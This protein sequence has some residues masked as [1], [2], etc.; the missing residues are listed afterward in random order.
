M[1]DERYAESDYAYGTAPNDFLREQAGRIPA[2]PVLCLAE[3]EGRN[4]VWLAEQGYDVTA[5]DQSAV[6]LAKARR[7]AAERGV[8]I[9]T[10]RSDLAHYQIMPDAWSG[11]VS[12]FAHVPPELRRLVHRQVVAGLRPGGV[13][14][15]EAYTPEQLRFGTGGPPEAALNMALEALHQELAGLD[16]EIG[17]EIVREVVEGRYHTGE[18]HV[19]QIVARR[20]GDSPRASSVASRTRAA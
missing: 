2:G 9:E 11:I 15:L 8:R 12:I 7:L 16:F 18:G 20:H 19:V 10:L 13:L 4:A 1:W 17:R 6:G 3:G 14:I 5:V